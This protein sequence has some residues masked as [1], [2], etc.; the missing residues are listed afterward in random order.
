[1]SPQ[2]IVV[3]LDGTSRL[4]DFGI[5]KAAS[6]ISVTNSG[7][8]KGKLHYMSPEQVQQKRLDRRADIFSAGVVLYEALTGQ[9]PFAGEDDGDVVLGIL[10]GEVPRASSVVVG[11]APALDSAVARALDRDRDNRFQ[12]AAEFQEAL[13]RAVAPATARD[14][15]RTVEHLGCAGFELRRAALQAALEDESISASRKAPPMDGPGPLADG[16]SAAPPQRGQNLMRTSAAPLHAESLANRKAR[17]VLVVGAVMAAIA[18]AALLGTRRSAPAD[19]AVSVTPLAP[20]SSAV[21]PDQAR[22]SAMEPIPT[23]EP[24]TSTPSARPSPPARL[25]DRP[26]SLPA[27]DLHRHNPYGT[28]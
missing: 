13:E 8:V 9:R 27:S 21:G 25:P 28:P 24:P 4:I 19:A 7:V 20:A 16:T 14:V 15:A 12:T 1:V 26:R 18:A 11:L 17:W 22:S 5:A 3:G 10:I 6:R 23:P 2:N